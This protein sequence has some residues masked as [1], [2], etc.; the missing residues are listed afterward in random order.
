MDALNDFNR[1][2]GFAAGNDALLADGISKRSVPTTTRRGGAT[3]SR[4]SPQR[5]APTTLAPWS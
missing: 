2:E 4:S 1:E 3:S 5:R